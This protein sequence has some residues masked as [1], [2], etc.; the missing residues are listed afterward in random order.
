M[1]VVLEIGPATVRRLGGDSGDRATVAAALH[2]I[3]DPVVLVGERPVEVAA[4]W[5]T[6]L[7]S[8]LR[9][10]PGGTVV[11]V[12]P[13]WWPQRRLAVV[14]GALES[15][16]AVTGAAVTRGV[17]TVARRNLIAGDDGPEVLVEIGPEIVAVS[18][19]T[20]LATCHRTEVTE[21]VR[22]VAGWADRH[23]R[24]IRIDVPDELPGADETARAI[25]GA[26]RASG[27]TARRVDVATAALSEAAA[28]T[29]GRP[30]RLLGRHRRRL[31]FVALAVLISAGITGVVATRTGRQPPSADGTAKLVEGAVAVDVP[32]GW[33]VRRVTGG[34]GSRRVVV[35]SPT[36]AEA[37]LHIT[38]TYAAG[39][40]LAQAA[41][42]LARAVS[43]QPPGVFADF[44]ANDD[45][46]GRA[47]VTYREVRPGKVV[48][49]SVVLAGGTRISIGCQS[50]AGR[51]ESVRAACEA[52]VR[53]ARELGR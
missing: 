11:I 7:A 1:T 27:I 35:S 10:R 28:L 32:V 8:V 2:G 20:D 12:Y 16:G 21:I 41:E 43:A 19:G 14:V 18:K 47:A 53:S 36:D 23:S 9:M 22:V 30:G 48:H 45:I 34:P 26:L 13:S 37:A 51:E 33:T 31:A 24:V 15:V 42:V 6:L 3:D 4:L 5:R 46:V 50:A 38:Q 52:A 49:W 40:D 44:R 39:S 17:V 29:A 25:A